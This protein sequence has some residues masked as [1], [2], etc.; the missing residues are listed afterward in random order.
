M[1]NGYATAALYDVKLF[2]MLSFSPSVSV[3]VKLMVLSRRRE[4][5][6]R[7]NRYEGNGE[8]GAHHRD[9]RSLVGSSC[10]QAH[11]LRDQQTRY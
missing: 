2:V 1:V 3:L 6:G 5:L 7:R 9:G 10:S 11:R 8:S 4:A